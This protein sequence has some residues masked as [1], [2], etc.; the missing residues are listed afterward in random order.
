MTREEQHEAFIE[1]IREETAPLEHA[2]HPSNDDLLALLSG[3]VSNERRSR[4]HAHLETCSD[5]RNRWKHLESILQDESVQL[6]QEACIPSLREKV[7]GRGTNRQGTFF[8]WLSVSF[9][10]KTFAAVGSAAAALLLAVGVMAPLMSNTSRETAAQLEALSNEMQAVQ[11]YLVA[12][13]T[14]A[15]SLSMT[16]ITEADLLRFNWAN[17]REY[18]ASVGDSWWTIAENELGNQSLWPLVWV[19]N[20]EQARAGPVAPGDTIRLPTDRE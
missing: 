14:I 10:T 4:L 6:R 19:L 17:T 9:R 7:A 11:S 3:D 20:A 2:T 12:N 1:A 15:N 13:Q 8:A 5:C 16:D 18:T